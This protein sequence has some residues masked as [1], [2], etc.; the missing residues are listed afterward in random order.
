[1]RVV[2]DAVSDGDGAG[3]DEGEDKNVVVAD[4]SLSAVHALI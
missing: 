4:L 3:A 2:S 1:M